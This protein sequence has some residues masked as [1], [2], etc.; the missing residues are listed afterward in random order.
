MPSPEV[1][2]TRDAIPESWSSDRAFLLAA[3][4]SAVGIGNIWRFP[5]LV[6]ENGGSAFVLV[7][8]LAVVAVA[9]PILTAELLMGRRGARSPGSSNHSSAKSDTGIGSQRRRL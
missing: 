4:G 6:G 9:M 8:A 1:P 7:Y 2:V 3:V 5:Y